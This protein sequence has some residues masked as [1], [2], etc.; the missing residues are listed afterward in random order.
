[1]QS[2]G[3][4]RISVRNQW[5][6]DWEFKATWARWIELSNSLVSNGDRF[7]SRYQIPKRRRWPNPIHIDK[8]IRKDLLAFVHQPSSNRSTTSPNNNQSKG[9]Q[10]RFGPFNTELLYTSYILPEH[11]KQQHQHQQF[12]H[13]HHH[14]R[15]FDSLILACLTIIKV[16]MV[17]NPILLR[18]DKGR[19]SHSPHTTT[20]NR[21]QVLLSLHLSIPRLIPVFPPF[22]SN[23]FFLLSCLLLFNLKWLL[24][25]KW[26]ARRLCH[27]RSRTYFGIPPSV[28]VMHVRNTPTRP[29]P[30]I[31]QM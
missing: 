26:T 22:P 18:I 11:L 28:I 6:W 2:T 30:T 17:S 7:G 14:S 12:H 5:S 27:Q 29:W 8:Q 21:Q 1:M 13:P 16:T 23:L 3:T 24:W 19:I 15:H 20:V 25:E 9:K 4:W 10:Q 31:P